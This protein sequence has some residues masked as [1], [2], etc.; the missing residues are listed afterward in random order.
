MVETHRKIALP[1]GRK[2]DPAGWDD[3]A[4]YAWRATLAPVSPPQSPDAPKRYRVRRVLISQRQ[5]GG[6]PYAGELLPGDEV[7]ADKWYSNN[8][9]HLQDG[10]GFVDLKDLEQV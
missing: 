5:E 3:A 4:F 10:R 6:P 2:K 8:K 9:I 7:V 1:A